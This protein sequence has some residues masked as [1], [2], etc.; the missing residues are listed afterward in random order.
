LE[1]TEVLAFIN[2]K[3]NELFGLEYLVKIEILEEKLND[4][5][6][7]DALDVF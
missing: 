6:L 1:K 4:S 2:S 3:I 5:L 7:N